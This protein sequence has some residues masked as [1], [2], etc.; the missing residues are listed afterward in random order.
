MTEDKKITKRTFKGVVVSDKA[1]KTAV[2]KVDR[3][4]THPKYHKR[5]TV[6]KNYKAHDERNE[7]KIGDK[8]IIQEC[9]PLSKDKRWRVM[10]KFGQGIVKDEIEEKELAELDSAREVE[11]IE[12]KVEEGEEEIEKLE[13]SNKGGDEASN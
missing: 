5:Y 10:G 1:D 2:V 3:I 9:R 12:K 11:R 4:K 7:Y 13:T 6:S 8:V